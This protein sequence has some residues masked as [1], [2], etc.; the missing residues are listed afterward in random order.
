MQRFS[1]PLIKKQ[2][3]DLP[4]ISHVAG[5]MRGEKWEQKIEIPGYLVDLGN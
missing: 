3:K 2:T 5:D 4:L 1:R